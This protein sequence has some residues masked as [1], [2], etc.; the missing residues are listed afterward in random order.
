MTA[1]RLVEAD[2]VIVGAGAVGM[3]IADTLIS[4]S[5]RT[6]A[7]VDRRH[8]PG[9]H[10]HDAYPFVRL[11]SPSANYGVNSLHLGS[12]RIEQAGLNEGLFELATGDEIRAYLDQ[13]M[14]QKLLPSGRVQYLPMHDFNGDCEATS[15]LTGEH[16]TLIWRCKLIDATIADTRVPSRCPPKFEVLDGVHLIPPN[17][18][19]ELSESPDMI[20]VIGAGKTAIDAVTWLLENGTDPDIITWVR[21]R[22][23]WLLNRATVQPDYRYFEQTFGWFTAQWEACAQAQSADDIFLCLEREGYVRRLDA[24]VLPTMYRCAIVSD[25]EYELVSRVSNVIR[26]GH[27]ERIEVGKVTLEHG[28]FPTTET[29]VFVDCSACGIPRKAAQPVFQNGRI[30]PQYLRQCSPTFSGALV[31]K[32][33]LMFENDDA[34]NAMSRPVPIPD[35]PEDLLSI[36]YNQQLN[37]LAW[38]QN[39]ELLEWLLKSRLDQFTR[40]AVRASSDEDPQVHQLLKRNRSAMRPAMERLAQL[41]EAA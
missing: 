24:S 7:I 17:S 5:D 37:A 38:H 4:E 27:V 31:A 22:D 40:M 28:A 10:W 26:M 15:M 13:V 20:V 34:K 1:N 25:G 29:A 8:K 33:E 16:S 30:V 6:V 39:P 12:D 41:L 21:P 9:G 11:H 23:A 19:P 14:R 32:L 36:L 2:Y 35:R 3:A 18:L